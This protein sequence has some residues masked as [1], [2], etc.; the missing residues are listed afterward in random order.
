MKESALG[1]GENYAI[2]FGPNITIAANI[3]TRPLCPKFKLI[4][5]CMSL[6]NAAMQDLS[7][8]V[9]HWPVT[10]KLKLQIN[11]YHTQNIFIY[12]CLHPGEIPCLDVKCG[13]M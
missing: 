12:V 1:L 8:V 2:C 5:A 10:W 3:T 6:M 4:G 9:T 7:Y 13:C 11:I